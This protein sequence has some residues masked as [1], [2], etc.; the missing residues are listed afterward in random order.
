MEERI[1]RTIR[2][3]RTFDQ[4]AQFEQNA[5]DRNG[6]TDEITNA[7]RLRSVELG[8]SMVAERTGLDLSNLSPAEEKIVHT[9]SEYVAI[10]RRQ[11]SKAQRT[12][13][14]LRNGG[15]LEAAEVSVSRSTPTQGFQNLTEADLPEL[16]Y[17]RIIVDHPQECRFR[18]LHQTSGK[19]SPY[20]ERQPTI[21]PDRRTRVLMS[22]K[23][24]QPSSRSISWPALK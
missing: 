14:Q 9:V 16:S 19:S 5:R 23:S 17:E 1:A 20:S 22:L 15:I 11:G 4:L 18:S 13:E 8:R 7:I 6:L 2:N 21:F 12:L 10:R 3:C 24:S